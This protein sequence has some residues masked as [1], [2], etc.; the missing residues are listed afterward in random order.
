[1]S[2]A[3]F[4]PLVQLWQ[5]IS[6]RVGATLG[7][8]ITLVAGCATT[9]TGALVPPTANLV[10]EARSRA[11]VAAPAIEALRAGSFADARRKSDEVLARDSG[12]PEAHFVRAV[13]RYRGRIDQLGLDLRTLIVGAMAT[14][15]INTSF[16]RQTLESTASELSAIDADLEAASAAPYFE[17]E[18]CPAC[19]E[20]DWNQSGEVDEGDR[21]LLEV[22]LDHA[23]RPLPEG[24]P[25]RRPAFAFDRGDLFWARAMLSHQRAIVDL[26]LAYEPQDWM[27]LTRG[28][29]DLAFRVADKGRVSSAKRGFLAG[30]SWAERA[31]QEYQAEIDDHAEWVPN[32]R[33]QDHAV[34]LS[35]DEALYAKW[36][37]VLED[38]R[39]LVEGEEGIDLQELARLAGVDPRHVPVGFLDVGRWFRDPVDFV[40]PLSK[41][42]NDADALQR[43]LGSS[44]RATMPASALPSRIAELKSGISVEEILHQKLKYILWLN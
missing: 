8:A 24:D 33:Q 13:A 27:A 30:L 25:R 28:R 43:A 11:A 32:P 4:T 14:G 37:A 36:G 44:W 15:R 12:Q 41:G 17:V 21:H 42:D 2:E 39:R 9:T 3:P 10:E 1:M 7:A 34:P 38:L 5:G 23:G 29:G 31:R 35:V 22:E 6:M 40:V 16:A 26:L 19:W 18:L 20:S